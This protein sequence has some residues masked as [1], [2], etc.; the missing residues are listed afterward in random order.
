MPAPDK[1]DRTRPL[2]YL[3]LAGGFAIFA[4]L[5]VLMSTRDI[6]LSLIFLGISFIASLMVLALLA[7]ATRPNGE[8]KLDLDE[9]DRGQGH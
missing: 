7:L 1:R 2:E 6:T 4:G 8:E 5:V 3:G 9:Q